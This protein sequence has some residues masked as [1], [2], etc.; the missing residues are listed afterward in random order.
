[1]TQAIINVTANGTHATKFVAK[2]DLIL[3][4][5]GTWDSASVVLQAQNDIDSAYAPIALAVTADGFAFYVFP[6]GLK[7]SLQL[8]TTGIITAADL[9]FVFFT[10]REY[11]QP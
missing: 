9:D 5:T 1:V 4:Y 6:R 2:R 3:Q 8:V 10:E 11:L 7:V